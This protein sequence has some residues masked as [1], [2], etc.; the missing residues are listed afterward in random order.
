MILGPEILLQ[1]VREN[2]LV[3]NLSERE[4]TNPEGAGFDLRLGEIY[5]IS[6]EAFLGV[7]ER[8]TP[9]VEL[10]AKY[11]P[12]NKQKIVIRPGDFYLVKTIEKVNTPLDITINF[13]PRST[14]FRSGLF[15]RTGNV[16]PGYQGELTFALKN[17]GPAV[18]TLE[19]GAR[20]IHA[21]FEQVLG[22]GAQYRGQWQG[23]RVTTDKTETQV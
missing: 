11:D 20:I 4:L 19:L 2:K 12:E 3:E 10:V 5:K 6:G 22:E 9:A 17:E 15:L 18:V 16:A 8:K 14:T 13:K 23:G 21:Q 1:L 7:T